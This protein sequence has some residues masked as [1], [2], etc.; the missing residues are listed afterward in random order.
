M[1]YMSVTHVTIKSPRR[2]VTLSSRN[3]DCLLYFLVYS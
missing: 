1:I 3:N 2:T